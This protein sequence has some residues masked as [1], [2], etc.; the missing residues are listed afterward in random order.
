MTPD[1]PSEPPFDHPPS[2]PADER[3]SLL[4]TMEGYEGPIDLLL[5]LAR[6]QKVDLARISILQLARQYLAFIDRAQALRLD[7]AADYLVMAAWLAYLKSRLLLP[8]TA[9]KSDE[10]DGETM[11]QALAFQL[12]RLQAMQAAA[13]AL[14]ARPRLGDRAFARGMPESPEIALETK[15]EAGLY[16]L[17]HAY[18]DIRWRA[19]SSIYALPSFTLMSMDEA[20]DRL[21]RML[22]DLPRQGP[23]SVWT[24]LSDFL[25]RTEGGGL[26]SRSALASLLTASLEMTKQGA[27]EIR[28]DGP[29]R[30]IYVRA[31]QSVPHR[32]PS[33]KETK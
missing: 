6:D 20:M 26:L 14:Y 3:E 30:P 12:R 28:Q 8:A 22:G 13:E 16:D 7:L 15:L 11:A 17:L 25:P 2:V 24:T 5:E 4:L 23:H 10:P 29:F 19:E 32:K 18:G 9:A 27:L 31:L 33:G 1:T 21:T